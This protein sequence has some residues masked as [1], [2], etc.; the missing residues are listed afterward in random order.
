MLYIIFTDSLCPIGAL[1]F[2]TLDSLIVFNNFFCVTQRNKC[3]NKLFHILSS[4]S[5][6]PSLDLI[7]IVYRGYL[8]HYFL[9]L[10]DNTFLLRKVWYSAVKR[11]AVRFII[12]TD[13]LIWQSS[14]QWLVC[15]TRWAFLNQS[16][17][18]KRSKA[19]ASLL[20][21]TQSQSF[22]SIKSFTIV[23]QSL[24]KKAEIN[25]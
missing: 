11:G 12:S 21:L 24:W 25:F 1:L 18:I 15:L 14:T 2:L 8:Q 9:T 6:H 13:G 3:Y 19:G 17:A 23:E 5:D 20:S 22:I 4:P 7:Q 10:A 16:Q